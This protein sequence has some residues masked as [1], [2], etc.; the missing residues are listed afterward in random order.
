METLEPLRLAVDGN[1]VSQCL[2]HCP[3]TI[4]HL[5][6]QDSVYYL[7]FIMWQT[8]LLWALHKLTHLISTATLS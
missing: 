7:L 2:F 4:W 3:L 8:L 1:E 5:C 6:P